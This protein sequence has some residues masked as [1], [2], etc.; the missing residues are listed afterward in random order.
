MKTLALTLILIL[1]AYPA[2]G[3]EPEAKLASS[4]LSLQASWYQQVEAAR[5]MCKIA[6]EDSH[7]ML[8]TRYWCGFTKRIER[9][10]EDMRKEVRRALKFVEV[11]GKQEQSRGLG[12][13]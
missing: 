11:L 2:P 7:P 12:P 9:E 5:V 6:R 13:P 10:Y 3:G 1:F 4:L 8:N